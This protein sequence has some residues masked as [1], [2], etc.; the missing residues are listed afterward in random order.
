MAL[1]LNEDGAPTSCLI[2]GESITQTPGKKQRIYCGNNCAVKAHRQRKKRTENNVD[3]ILDRAELETVENNIVYDVLRDEVR[4]TINQRVRD[5]VLGAADMLVNMLPD[6][7][8][9]LREDLHSEDW[10]VRA[11]AVNNLLKY[12][13][14]MQNQASTEEHTASITIKHN[15]PVPETPLGDAVVEIMD[16][17]IEQLQVTPGP[18]DP[19]QPYDPVLNP[20]HFE[21]DWPL[22]RCEEPR[23][24][25]PDNMSDS[26]RLVDRGMCKPCV[27]QR[28]MLEKQDQVKSTH[29]PDE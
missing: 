22:C 23:R 13:M 4:R 3:S 18:V 2:C 29:L 7:M 11:R 24:H 14:P 26:E 5:K 19:T 17:A 6:A 8:V 9:A 16:D 20:E 12:G 25:H 10:A 28:M 15:I 21:K 1:D 27:A